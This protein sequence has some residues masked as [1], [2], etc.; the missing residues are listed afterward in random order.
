MK[1]RSVAKLSGLFSSLLLVSSV[2]IGS[3]GSWPVNLRGNATEEGGVSER[4]VEVSFGEISAAEVSG[5]GGFTCRLGNAVS[6]RHNAT[7]RL[8][9]GTEV[10]S[11]L[12]VCEHRTSNL[13]E[14]VAQLRTPNAIKLVNV[15]GT[16]Q[17][18]ESMTVI[19]GRVFVSNQRTLVY[20]VNLEGLTP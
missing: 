12:G 7:G 5:A 9:L 13:V 3:I 6:E 11:I 2:G 20:S 10:Y 17:N 8:T 16:A 15:T 19:N 18:V 14:I 4:P 1:P